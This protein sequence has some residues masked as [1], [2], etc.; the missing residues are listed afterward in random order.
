MS[1]WGKIQGGGVKR[2]FNHTNTNYARTPHLSARLDQ[3]SIQC[4]AERTDRFDSHG[5]WQ[6]IVHVCGAVCKTSL[7]AAGRPTAGRA[8]LAIL[9]RLSVTHLT[10]STEQLR[11]LLRLTM[12]QCFMSQRQCMAADKIGSRQPPQLSLHVRYMVKLFSS[13]DDPGREV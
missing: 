2:T 3:V 4:T 8:K 1:S 11:R 7:M 13:R 5:S 9:P 6:S 10:A 12:P